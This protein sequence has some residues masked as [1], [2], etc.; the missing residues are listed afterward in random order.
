MQILLEIQASLKEYKY[1]L[2]S[3]LYGHLRKT[4]CLCDKYKSKN[5]YSYL[6]IMTVE[7]FNILMCVLI[8][9]G[10]CLNHNKRFT[11]E[12][13]NLLEY[14]KRLKIEVIRVCQIFTL[15]SL[16]YNIWYSLEI[17]IGVLQTV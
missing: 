11:M 14:K 8:F 4:H 5:T 7:Y 3:F 16:C 2:I 6:S 9:H 10:S 17:L 13:Y 15:G 1:L 12:H